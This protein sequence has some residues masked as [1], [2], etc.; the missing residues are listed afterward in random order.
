MSS[1]S[2][3]VE[4]AASVPAQRLGASTRRSHAGSFAQISPR[5]S[6]HPC[7][8]LNLGAAARARS[9][10]CPKIHPGAKGGGDFA[11]L[12]ER[13]W[14]VLGSQPPNTTQTCPVVGDNSGENTLL[15]QGLQLTR[16]A[17]AS[18]PLARLRAPGG[19]PLL[20]GQGEAS[21]GGSPWPQTA[22]G[23]APEPHR[24][25][26]Q[27]PEPLSLPN[28]PAPG[29]LRA[30]VAAALPRKCV[31]DRR[32]LLSL[33]AP[34]P[35]PSAHPSWGASGSFC[36]VPPLWALLHAGVWLGLGFNCTF[37]FFFFLTC[38]F[39]LSTPGGCWVAVGDVL[40]AG[41]G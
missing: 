1:A 6:P 5:P 27:P 13:S 29:A 7:Q 4:T 10:E 22:R 9:P 12:G 34:L 8:G 28:L 35:L 32:A 24:P 33:L 31:Q 11:R 40:R 23:E 37:F 14:L 25:Y 21:R 20:S 39:V 2:Q 19:C 38:V 17:R 15:I 30:A 41:S 3:G 26:Q 36:L 16:L 18:L